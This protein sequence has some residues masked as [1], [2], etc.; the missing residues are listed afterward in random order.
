MRWACVNASASMS[1]GGHAIRAAVAGMSGIVSW[2]RGAP[3]RT[4]GCVKRMRWFWLVLIASLP[5]TGVPVRAVVGGAPVA[6]NALAIDAET[7]AGTAHFWRG[8][9]AGDGDAVAAVIEIPCGTT[10]KF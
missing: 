4:G 10:G 2:S 1:A 6:T 7:V 8:F 9:P 3:R 5:C